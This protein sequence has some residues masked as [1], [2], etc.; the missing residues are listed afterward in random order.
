MEKMDPNGDGQITLDEYRQAW[1]KR[2]EKRFQRLDTDG[3]GVL[4]QAEIAK[5]REKFAR[6]RDRFREQRGEPLPE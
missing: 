6:M 5:I 2:I 3:D 4:S 1:Q